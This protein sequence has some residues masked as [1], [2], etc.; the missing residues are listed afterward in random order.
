M[1]TSNDGRSPA[2]D[3]LRARRIR[4]AV[5]EVH[6]GIPEA[7][8]CMPTRESCWRA[9][10]VRRI[11]DGAGRNWVTMRSAC[12]D[13]MLIGFDP[14]R[15][16]AVIDALGGGKDGIAA[17]DSIAWL[18]MSSLVAPPAAAWCGQVLRS[19]PERRLQRRL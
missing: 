17:N 2:R 10:V 9:L 1:G 6:A 7:D 12:I 18:R 4:H 15:L 3:A 8:A 19:R 13:Q 16:G 11:V 14:D 5:R